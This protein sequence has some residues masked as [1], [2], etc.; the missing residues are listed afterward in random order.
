MTFPCA[1]IKSASGLANLSQ[2]SLES[3][4]AGDFIAISVGPL[5]NALVRKGMVISDPKKDLARNTVKFRA[6][7][8]MLNSVVRLVRTDEVYLYSHAPR[9]RCIIEDIGEKGESGK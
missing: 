9:I 8:S 5:S 2:S 4:E 7:I 1:W 3:A 6:K